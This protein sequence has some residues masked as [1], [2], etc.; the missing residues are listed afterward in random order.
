MYEF[1]R[2]IIFIGDGDKAAFEQLRHIV[3]NVLPVSEHGKILNIV[4]PA[5]VGA[6]GA[7]WLARFFE[8]H[9]SL[10]DPIS[11][12]PGWNMQVHLPWKEFKHNEL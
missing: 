9:P 6:V 11:S 4:D 5:F 12:V 1:L 7:A 10:L 8:K 3:E 2:G